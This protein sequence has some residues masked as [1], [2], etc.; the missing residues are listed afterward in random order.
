MYKNTKS[1]LDSAWCVAFSSLTT[2]QTLRILVNLQIPPGSASVLLV[3][4]SC[5][6]DRD[7]SIV[8]ILLPVE[9][10]ATVGLKI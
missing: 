4:N 2:L 10:P 8:L 6:G 5:R 7:E 3:L 9:L 1:V